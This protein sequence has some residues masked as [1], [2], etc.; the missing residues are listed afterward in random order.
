MFRDPDYIQLD[1][2]AFDSDLVRPGLNETPWS[3][4]TT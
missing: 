2:W 1:L 4:A 3:E